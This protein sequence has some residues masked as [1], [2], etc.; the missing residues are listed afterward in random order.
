MVFRSGEKLDKENAAATTKRRRP[1]NVLARGRSKSVQGKSNQALRVP[2]LPHQSIPNAV[3]PSA[4]VG[5]SLSPTS[6]SEQL[7]SFTTALAGPFLWAIR[8][9]P[10]DDKP[11]ECHILSD[12]FGYAMQGLLASLCT[13]ALL[14]KWYMEVPQRWFSVFLLDVSKQVIGALWYHLLNMVVATYLGEN[15]G[16]DL[17]ADECAWYFINFMVDTTVGLFFNVMFV[18]LS[19]RLIGYESGEYWSEE[20]G[21]H[22]ELDKGKWFY[23][24][25]IYLAIVTFSKMCV[26][27]VILA[28]LPFWAD[29]GVAGTTWIE[30]VEK[31]LFFVMVAVPAVMDT[32]FFCVIDEV[33]KASPEHTLPDE[34]NK[35]EEAVKGDVS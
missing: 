9:D 32:L 33:I 30:D 15:V 26:L 13:A 25:S 22:S 27:T 16:A 28:F 11:E 6:F 1:T 10:D 18:K 3:N 2:S 34:E 35:V 29:L 7:N 5:H 24:M 17:K 21:H 4:L 14:T 12:C 31:R 8:A 20:D 19:E 23:Q